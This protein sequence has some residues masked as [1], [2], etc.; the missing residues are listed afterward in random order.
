MKNNIIKLIAIIS[1]MSIYAGVGGVSGGPKPTKDDF[2]K[3]GPQTSWQRILDVTKRNFDVKLEGT[4]VFVSRPVSIFETCLNGDEIQ[5]TRK[6][7]IYKTRYVGKSHYGAD[8]DGFKTEIVGSK[9]LTYPI[10]YTTRQKVC[11]NNGKRCREV[12]KEVSTETIKNVK[13]KK[14]IVYRP[15]SDR[16]REVEQDH[17]KKEYIIPYCQ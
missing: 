2:S 10:N 6:F 3:L 12:K 14:V 13:V 17:F 4:T 9:Y 8:K 5:T 11:N 1:T 15:N 16:P 7:P